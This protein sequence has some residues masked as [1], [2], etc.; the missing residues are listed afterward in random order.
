MANECQEAVDVSPVVLA[1]T[2]T[3]RGVPDSRSVGDLHNC[4][5]QLV[6]PERPVSR[7]GSELAGQPGSIGARV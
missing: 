2:V 5:R 1:A 7:V 4:E 3:M 6:K